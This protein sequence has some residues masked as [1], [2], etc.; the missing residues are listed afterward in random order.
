MRPKE[1]ATAML[2][3][4]TRSVGNARFR[5]QF[6]IKS[7]IANGNSAMPFVPVVQRLE[8]DD[9]IGLKSNGPREVR[10]DKNSKESPPFLAEKSKKQTQIEKERIQTMTVAKRKA[11]RSA[12]RA[13]R[14]SRRRGRR[15]ARTVRR[16]GRIVARKARRTARKGARRVRRAGRKIGRA[17]R[18][19]GRS[20]ESERAE[21]T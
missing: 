11:R 18:I 2:F 20:I 19:V 21:A 6:G 10:D 7:A 3:S 15:A 17:K 5:S 4:G 12:R 13:A 1:N 8:H 14:V 9:D 16:A